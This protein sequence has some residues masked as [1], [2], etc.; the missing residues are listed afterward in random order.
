MERHF[1]PRQLFVQPGVNV[2]RR[3]LW[4][5]FARHHMAVEVADQK[6]LSAHLSKRIAIRIHEKQIIAP[7]HHGRKMVAGA[8]LQ[9]VQRRQLKA[10]GQLRAGD[11]GGFRDQI[12]IGVTDRTG[13]ACQ[14]MCHSDDS[15]L[16]AKGRAQGH[17]LIQGAQDGI[18]R[19]IRQ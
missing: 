8:L 12:Q 11:G 16:P 17:D 14:G 4:L 15:D 18:G 7:Q 10:R 2:E 6:I 5:P 1:H 3:R 9:P 19:V 13:A